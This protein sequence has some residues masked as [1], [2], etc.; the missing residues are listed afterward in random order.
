MKDDSLA[1]ERKLLNV[2]MRG[3]DFKVFPA[4]GNSSSNLKIPILLHRAQTAAVEYNYSF[5]HCC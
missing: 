5:G 1:K 4:S 2:V 3:I